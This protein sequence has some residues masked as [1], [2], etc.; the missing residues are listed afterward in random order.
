LRET[1]PLLP[2]KSLD[3]PGRINA[4]RPRF[5]PFSGSSDFGFWMQFSQMNLITKPVAIPDQNPIVR[6]ESIRL[7]KPGTKDPWTSLSR[8]TLNLLVL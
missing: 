7:P 6:P 2:P 3:L 5:K 8:S 4:E 1:I